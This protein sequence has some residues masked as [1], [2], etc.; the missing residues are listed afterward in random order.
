MEAIRT[1]TE[2]AG[3]GG[4]A[5]DTT[6][7]LRIRSGEGMIG[8]TGVSL[9]EGRRLTDIIGLTAR[10]LTTCCLEASRSDA[11]WVVGSGV[12]QGAWSMGSDQ[13]RPCS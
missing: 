13:Q 12:G 1:R 3:A 9:L 11:A 4:I 7:G 6:L 2:R 8:E 5:G 10:R